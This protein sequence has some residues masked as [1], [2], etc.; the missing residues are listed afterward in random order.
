MAIEHRLQLS[1]L[2]YEFARDECGIQQTRVQ[3]LAGLLD[4]ETSLPDA[5][6]QVP[7][8]LPDEDVIAIRIGTQSGSLPMTLHSLIDDQVRSEHARLRSQIKG[9]VIYPVIVTLVIAAIATFLLVKIWPIFEAIMHEMGIESYPAAFQFIKEFAEA[10]GLNW[11]LVGAVAI[12]FLIWILCT[13]KA[14]RTVRRALL[15]PWFDMR[16]VDLLQSLS[17]VAEAGRPIVGAIS[18]LARYHHDPTLRQKLL[19]VRN[20]V[21]HGTDLWSALRDVKLLTPAEVALMEVSQKVGNCP[22]AMAQLAASKRRRIQR[23]LRLLAQLA[24]PASVL[25]LAAVVFAFCLGV[26]GPLINMLLYQA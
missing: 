18:T 12:L 21:E 22:W 14:G 26:F 2:L 24:E 8:V 10:F 6:E 17:V 19:F 16:S 20:E 1:P 15:R 3:R 5:L 11:L 13:E 7:D 4:E 23:R 9:I 25:V